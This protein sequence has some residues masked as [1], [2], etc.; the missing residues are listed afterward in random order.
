M[1]AINTSQQSKSLKNQSVYSDP[2]TYRIQ[3]MIQKN[4]LS[5][6]VN[7]VDKY[8]A[9]VWVTVNVTINEDHFRVQFA[10]L[11][12]HFSCVDVILNHVATVINLPTLAEFHHQ[13]TISC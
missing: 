8:V 13:N 5:L 4:N 2:Q 3:A 1:V 10:N 7:F 12:R 11:F 6:I 9:R